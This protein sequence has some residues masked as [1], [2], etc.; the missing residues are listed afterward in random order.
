MRKHEIGKVFLPGKITSKKAIVKVGI[1]P[2]VMCN[3]H[4]LQLIQFCNQVRRKIRAL[5]RVE[6]DAASVTTD[7]N[8]L[9]RMLKNTDIA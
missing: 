9:P 5:I 8:A 1:V 2:G 6:I 7:Q 3:L 4:N